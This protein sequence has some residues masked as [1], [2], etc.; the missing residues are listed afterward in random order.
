M[1]RRLA[2][3]LVLVL[4]FVGLIVAAATSAGDTATDVEE[5][6]DRDGVTYTAKKVQSG[7]DDRVVAVVPIYN[8]IVSGDSPADGSATGAADIVRV[9]DEIADSKDRFDGVILELETPGGGVLAAQEIH[10][11]VVRLKEDTDLPV[12]AWMRDVAASAGYYI[13]AP[14]DHIIAAGTTF[15]G[16]IGVIMEYYEAAELADEIGVKSVVIKSGKLKDMGNPLR[17]ITPEERS[18]LQSV[19][20]EAYGEFVDVVADGR[21]LSEAKVREIADGRIYSGTQ[22]KELDLVDEIGIRRDAYD[23]MAKLIAKEDK[24]S[25]DGEDLDVVEFQRSFSFLD[26]IAAGAAPTLDGLDA[27]R[28]AGKFLRGDGI[29]AKALGMRPTSNGLVNLEYRAVLGG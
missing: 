25:T 9:L 2:I 13:A 5:S 19:I 1:S 20:D 4:V 23:A 18:V 7:T 24:G 22:A 21:D 29:D 3:W 11:A 28:A 26:T 16:S 8:A 12:L 27:A 17:P 15:T 6:L 14:T 10:D